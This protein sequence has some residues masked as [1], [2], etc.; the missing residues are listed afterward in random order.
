MQH[1]IKQRYFLSQ[2]YQFKRDV[3]YAHMF[4]IV[5]NN[6]LKR[7]PF[8]GQRYIRIYRKAIASNVYRL[9]A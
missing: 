4:N 6:L 8:S 5:F 7:H 2:M 9:I 1:K 3:L